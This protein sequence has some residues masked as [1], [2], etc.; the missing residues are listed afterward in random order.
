M[1]L[2]HILDEIHVLQSAN[3]L[4]G[5]AKLRL[6]IWRDSA[7]LFAPA[8]GNT[9]HLLT[10]EEA[11]FD[12]KPS[13]IHAGF[14]ESIVNHPSPYSRFKTMSAIQYVLAGIEKKERGLDEIIITDHRGF[15]SE[16]LSSNVFWKKGDVYGTPPITTG[17]VEGVMRNWLIKALTNAGY[18]VEEQLITPKQLMDARHIFTSNSMEIRHITAID[19]NVFDIDL[20]VQECLEFIA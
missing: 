12:K 20:T 11:K 9:H 8:N 13:K 2:K 7:G 3:H 14:S 5:N 15:V 6:M 16:V 19:S 10:L 18:K 4:P 17:C 1:D